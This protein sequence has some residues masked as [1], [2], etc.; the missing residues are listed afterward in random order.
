MGKILE[1]C[2]IIYIG[3]IYLILI[4]GVQ[5]SAM[6]IL[7]IVRLTSEMLRMVLSIGGIILIYN[8][9]DT[10]LN[11]KA[12]YIAITS[13]ELCILIIVGMK[14][15][16]FQ[17]VAII[18]TNYELYK[19]IMEFLQVMMLAV[20]IRYIDEETNIKKIW[21][22]QLYVIVLLSILI[23][24]QLPINKIILS[25]FWVKIG[26][27][28][29]ICMV[30]IGAII[31]NYKYIK[32]FQPIHM[33]HLIYLFCIKILIGILGIIGILNR[34]FMIQMMQYVLQ[35]AFMIQVVNYINEFTLEDTWVKVENWVRSK[36]KEAF[37]RQKEQEILVL[38]TKEIKYLIEKIIAKT[39]ILEVQI[40][41]NSKE[42]GKK[43]IDKIRNNGNRLLKLS[44]DI[45]ELKSYELGSRLPI[46]QRVNLTE[47]VRGI[48]ESLETYVSQQ[49]I[50]L[51]YI[52]AHE[53]I[54]ADIDLDAVERIILNLIS[55]SVKYNKK[56]GKIKV[57]LSEKKR[58]IYLCIQDSGI[59]IP[60][61][62]LES[63]F[64]KFKRVEPKTV[65]KQEGSG[66]GL[67]IVKSLVDMHNGKI[68]VISREGRGTL[69]S[70]VLP[71]EQ[72]VYKERVCWGKEE[73]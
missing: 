30:I 31:R 54:I 67:S 69:I 10:K 64:E 71:K 46:F 40:K 41:V 9:I 48:V 6:D 62:Y 14:Q 25:Q 28:V 60:A 72:E 24:V 34:G 38:A 68:Q 70:I 32:A 11:N 5:L 57:V 4:I 22:I 7:F 17:P 55:N 1:L 45:L 66:L 29:F 23:F 73:K 3:I 44:E 53:G 27:R 65:E 16:L 8:N 26:M 18:N 36:E 59:G 15:Y 37:N 12:N 58:N 47:F 21:V 35:I 50:R 2:T 19:F 56:N 52:A 42:Q 20:S 43:Y 51:E 13:F 49:N 63:I 39:K 33:K 61:Y